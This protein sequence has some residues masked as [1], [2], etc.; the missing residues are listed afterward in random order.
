[1]TTNS[2]TTK[3]NPPANIRD[4]QQD[5]S[6]AD[7]WD[8][9]LYDSFEGQIRYLI[10]TD[11]VPQNQVRFFN[12]R[13]RP[14]GQSS[15]TPVPWG[16]FPNVLRA[17]YGPKAF[18]EADKLA[19]FREDYSGPGAIFADPNGSRTLPFNYRRQD[20]YLEW[21]IRRDTSTGKIKEIFFTCEG[22]EYWKALSKNQQLLLQLYK[23]YASPEVELSDLL[24]SDDVYE[25]DIFS[26]QFV[27]AKGKYN[28]YNKWNLSAAIHLTH[29]SNTLGAEINLA[30]RATA[31]RER[32]GNTLTDA[33]D[34]I[35]CAGYG[36]VNRN[37]DPTIGGGV[38]SLVRDRNWVSLRD[39]VGLYIFGIDPSQFTKPDGSPISDFQDRYWNV[40]RGSKD[41]QTILRASVRVPDG[42]MFDGKPLLLGD[43]LVNGDPLQYG[44]QVANAVTIGLYAISVGGAPLATPIPCEFKCCQNKRFP[45]LD[46][47][48]SINDPCPE[49]EVQLMGLKAKIPPPQG[50]S[51]VI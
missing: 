1:M 20:E 2:T 5:P 46:D 9:F 50:I 29:I 8:Q 23:T 34:L 16:G 41:D 42:E 11:H 3:F 6:L 33:H 25:Y 38:N 51:R 49:D 4:F 44:G 32:N 37:S 21:A 47:T 24:F 19:T 22:P 12:P 43:L 30:A 35:C 17:R 18:E 7:D 39:P 45:D 13:K 28:R 15:V 36:G 10:N 14:T 40:L 27:N 31:L 48:V 26:Q